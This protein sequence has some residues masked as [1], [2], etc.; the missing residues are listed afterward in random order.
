VMPALLVITRLNWRL[1]CQANEFRMA[2]AAS[3]YQP[4][5]SAA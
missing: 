5:V 4:D 3:P 2:A 1:A